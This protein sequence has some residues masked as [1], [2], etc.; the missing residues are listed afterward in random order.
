MDENP[1]VHNHHQKFQVPNGATE[2]YKANLG[3]G[4]F[5][6]I[7]RIHTAYIG[8]DSSI[9]GT[10][11]VWWSSWPKV[12]VSLESSRNSPVNCNDSKSPG[13]EQLCGLC[14]C[15]GL[16]PYSIGPECSLICKGRSKLVG[17]V[18]VAGLV[19][20]KPPF[21]LRLRHKINRLVV[22]KHLVVISP[23]LQGGPPSSYNLGYNSIYRW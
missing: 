20:V 21:F 11:N 14:L 6:Y 9:V 10:W 4:F 19:K 18:E 1:D 17:P 15:W 13:V 12:K 5:P 7:S 16:N 23:H 3:E 8:E 2:P 22:S